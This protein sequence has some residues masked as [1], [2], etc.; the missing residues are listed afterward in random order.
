MLDTWQVMGNDAL[1]KPVPAGQIDAIEKRLIDAIRSRSAGPNEARAL[2]TT[3]KQF[4]TD[5]SGA[6]P[7]G[8]R[9]AHSTIHCPLP[10]AH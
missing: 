1:G 4:D 5:K 3:F 7:E 8:S 2:E 6:L 10:A 9:N